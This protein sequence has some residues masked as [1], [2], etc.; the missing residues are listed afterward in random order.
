[1]KKKL[2][3]VWW[4]NSHAYKQ[5]LLAMRLIVFLIVFSV[6][7]VTANTGHSQE[8]KI[9]LQLKNATL[10]DVLDAIENNS[11]YYFML[12]NK[13]IDL[14]RRIDIDVQEKMV[15]DILSLLSEKIGIKYKIY[16]R[17][18]VL[19]PG[20]QKLNDFSV[21]KQQ[22]SVT[23]KVTDFSGAPL[24]GVTVVV[25]GTTSGVI[26]DAY[27]KFTLTKVP[28]NATLQFSFVGMKTQ[29]VNAAGKTSINVTLEEETVGIEEVVAIGYGTQKKQSVSNA[30]ST[31]NSKQIGGLP[32]MNTA[33]ALTA[34]VS[35]VSTQATSGNPGEA[36]VIRIRGIGSFST[37]NDPLIVVDGYPLNSA[38][39]FNSINPNDIQSIQILK[40]A[41]STAIY[42][43]RGG[44]GVVMVTTKKG[45]AGKPRL[46]FSASFGA[47][48]L[49]KKIEML[50]SEQFLE[51]SKEAL[52]Q[53]N[54]SNIPTAYNNPNFQYDNT[55]WQ[56]VVFRTA[57][58]KNIQ[59]SASGG[60]DKIQ[61]MVS[62]GYTKDEGILKG[63]DYE[64]YNFRANLNTKLNDKLSVGFNLSPT[65]T[66][67]NQRPVSSD[68]NAAKGGEVKYYSGIPS[69][70]YFNGAVYSALILPPIIPVY[71][72]HNGITDYNSPTIDDNFKKTSIN[73]S[74]YNPLAVLNEIDDRTQTFQ[75]IGNL[76]LEY[77]IL[78]DLKFK[79]SFGGDAAY[80]QRNIFWPS[81][82]AYN[83]GTTASYSNPN[84]A[85]IRDGYRSW[86][87]FGWVWDQTLTYDRTLSEKHHFTFLAGYSA[88]KHGSES[89]GIYGKNY[90]SDGVR[91]PTGAS[92]TAG[93]QTYSFVQ[94]LNSLIS[95]FGRLNYNFGEK[96]YFMAAYR[97]DGSSKFGKNVR[98]A[99][100]PSF[101][102]AWRINEEAFLKDNSIISELKLRASYGVTGVN[103]IGDFQ[104]LSTLT[105]SGLGYA[106][107]TGTGSLIN[108]Y[109]PD[110]INNLDLTW[111]TNKQIDFGLDLALL[112]GR[113][114]LTAELYK[115]TSD[116][117]L[118][119]TNVSALVGFSPNMMRNIGSIENKGVE[120][121]ITSSNLT[122]DFKWTTSVN[123]SRNRNKIIDYY[124]D[125]A[126]YNASVFGFDTSYILKEG[127]SL[128]D[129]YGM[130]FDGVY[131]DQAEV[132][133]GPIWNGN[134][135]LTKPGDPRFKDT[136]GN[137]ILNLNDQKVFTNLLPK[138][139]YGITNTF[140]YKGFDLMVLLQGVYGQ[141]VIDGIGRNL[142]GGLDG[143]QNAPVSVIN[144]WKSADEPGDG[145]MPGVNISSSLRVFSSRFV[146]DASF[147]RIRDI[148][149]SY[150]LP[151]PLTNKLK[152]Q[153]VKL[154]LALQNL[155]T[156]TDYYG[157][158]PE[159]N[160]E[161]GSAIRMNVE[162]GSY[163]L[164]RTTV[165]GVNFSL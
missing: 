15:N 115:R 49:A 116:G 29:E 149:L 50:N 139:T 106:F 57:M 25:K 126:D 75:A 163:P 80:N 111:E 14:S 91:T 8:A 130:V 1:M 100:F 158:D 129:V 78:N 143:N 161:G 92:T 152:L 39:D 65:Y 54:A 148:T 48:T 104:T 123:Y 133:A 90:I 144:R 138:F 79:S 19:S 33:Q 87:N 82:I 40:D 51:Y 13:L 101:S 60:T 98:W 28:E 36:P 164:P 61:Y 127:G 73:Q 131:K 62:G 150:N 156:F 38:S 5:F 11:S 27:G 112:K 159:V 34:Q 55:D 165:F 23:G 64:R 70:A 46:N 2:T 105:S 114:S 71:Q 160:I 81:Y 12:N 72:V 41:A 58:T 20:D 102:A 43:S 21:S 122:G 146:K 136:D 140:S 96:Y 128:G 124:K 47:N 52:N 95:Y 9:T 154:Y 89:V 103:S 35:G 135:A 155:Y 84:I 63:T 44:N 69:I 76:Y 107:G 162:Q 24:P 83:T 113:F 4:R 110:G 7:S 26:T 3:L 30:V 132:N 68:N 120:L 22:K 66:K 145:T 134:P 151:K 77:E 86:K 117:M 99:N 119:S 42:G 18:I 147:L 142:I 6:V 53:R 10:S 32:V 37:S 88:E 74:F 137:G 109:A 157:F 94:G 93:D 125:G 97:R 118:A 141:K 56:D 108:G 121:E 16:D 59:L 31:V 45:L 85:A 17:Q 67:R 153:G